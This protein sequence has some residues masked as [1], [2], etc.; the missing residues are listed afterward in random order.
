[1]K[2]KI[3]EKTKAKK[4]KISPIP[5]L[6]ILPSLVLFAAFIYYPFGKT[7]LSSFALTTE[8]GKFINWAG[9]ANWERMFTNPRFWQVMRNTFVFAGVD[10]SISFSVAMLFALLS[11]KARKGA[12]IYQT[13]YALPM[14]V[15]ASASSAAW[16]FFFRENGGLLNQVL[17]T[18]VAWLRDPKTALIM[19]AVATAWSHIAVNYIYL[20]V[21]FRNVSDDLLEA[22]TIDGAGPFM[23]IWKIMIPMASPQIFFVVFLTIVRSFKTITQIKLLTNGG[24]LY[25]T[26]TMLFEVYSKGAVGGQFEYACCQAIVL[27]AV[28]FIITRVQ[29]LF[30]RKVVHYQ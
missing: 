5:Y 22:A 21:G 16:R 14:A 23:R 19:V 9:L 11:S 25:A 12:R 28:I 3:S 7:I 20:L 1:M 26:T 13:L 17:E 24:P 15:S 6:L 2:K 27:F 18:D 10:F 8:T 29:L 30:E 4:K